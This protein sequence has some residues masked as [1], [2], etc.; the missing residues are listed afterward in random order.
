MK[1][2]CSR[3]THLLR[4]TVGDPAV[5]LSCGWIVGI[6]VAPTGQELPPDEVLEDQVGVGLR[7]DAPPMLHRQ[8]AELE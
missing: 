2:G 6:N 7:H 8:A 5:H 3:V 1:T 4:A